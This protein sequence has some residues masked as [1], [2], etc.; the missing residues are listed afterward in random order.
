MSGTRSMRREVRKCYKISVEGSQGKKLLRRNWKRL[1]GN[2]NIDVK[3][4]QGTDSPSL[5]QS[6][7]KWQV[8][9]NMATNLP[10]SI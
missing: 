8:L 1:E 7:V 3:N 9:V 5:V 6:T 2:I 4:V 10:S